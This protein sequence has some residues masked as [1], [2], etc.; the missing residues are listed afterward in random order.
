LQLCGDQER[1][2]EPLHEFALSNIRIVIG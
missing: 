1:G 2:E